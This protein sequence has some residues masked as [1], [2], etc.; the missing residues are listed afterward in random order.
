MLLSGH[1]WCGGQDHAGICP[2][3]ADTKVSSVPLQ[4]CC[5]DRTAIACM[6]TSSP[7]PSFLLT[8]SRLFIASF[9]SSSSMVSLCQRR[10]HSCFN[11]KDL[12]LKFSMLLLRSMPACSLTMHHHPLCEFSMMPTRALG[13]AYLA[14]VDAM[15]L[16]EGQAPVRPL[17][18]WHFNGWWRCFWLI[19]NR[20][21]GRYLGSLLHPLL[22]DSDLLWS[23]GSMTLQCPS[24]APRRLVWNPL[25]S[26]SWT[27]LVPHSARLDSLWISTTVRPN[28]LLNFVD[29]MQQLVAENASLMSVAIYNCPMVKVSDWFHNT[30]T[31]APYLLKVCP[32]K[33]SWTA[34]L[35]R[36]TQHSGQW[37][38]QS[39]ST[40]TW[41]SR[42]GFTFLKPW[43]SLCC[44]MARAAGVSSLLD[45][46]DTFIIP[47][48]CGRDA[49][50]T[51]ASGM[52]WTRMTVTSMRNGSCH[53]LRFSWR[54]ID[55]CL[56]YNCNNMPHAN[57]ID[58]LSSGADSPNGWIPAL[59][60][61]LQWLVL[62]N[63]THSRAGRDLTTEEIYAWLADAPPQE[64]HLIRK[65]VQRYCLQEN[66]LWMTRQAHMAIG[67][68]CQQAGFQL[69]MPPD[70]LHPDPAAF[71]CTHC[72]R[73]FD[74][75]QGLSAHL[76]TAHHVMSLERQYVY[77]PTC[78]ICGRCFWTSQRMQQ[79]LRYTRRF[80]DGCLAQL[81]QHF[82]PLEE[83]IEVKIPDIY[84]GIHRLPC[85]NAEGP[86]ALMPDTCWK[87]SHDRALE[88]WT[89]QWTA[90]GMP[91]N[92]PAGALRDLAGTFSQLTWTGWFRMTRR[93]W[94][95]WSTAGSLELMKLMLC[96]V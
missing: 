61:G 16:T 39:S 64:A 76:W 95:P 93:M 69:G 56:G 63:P 66:V 52:I 96:Q 90:I 36:P 7:M 62:H 19:Y 26:R 84:A 81:V 31:W 30:S 51:P 20:L 21:C 35:E 60:H 6:P 74:T 72:L 44:S 54:S 92:P 41:P 78:V 91:S 71:P 86:V 55:C 83:P 88:Q 1:H 46:I 10:L 85:T 34:E 75:P 79:H 67:R 32:W 49:L 37:H 23:H 8:W 13:F 2:N 70:D 77:G 38:D 28:L 43:Y 11:K 14:L 53:R 47:S 82:E 40:S 45:N 4:A 17:R 57:Y 18:I 9:D 65:T 94:T 25:C 50:W 42:C 33:L 3:L 29:S 89:E 27:V 68:I 87:R 24:P 5:C 80:P 15:R 12:T 22:L 73:T 58:L 48:S 59:R